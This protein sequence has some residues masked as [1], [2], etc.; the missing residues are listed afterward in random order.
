M[1]YKN[2]G[3]KKVIFP[4]LPYQFSFDLILIFC[5]LSTKLKLGPQLT[6]LILQGGHQYCWSMPSDITLPIVAYLNISYGD[7]TTT[8]NGE[9]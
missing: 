7:V 8:C 4:L 3:V 2:I 6:G 1:F 5:I 9:T